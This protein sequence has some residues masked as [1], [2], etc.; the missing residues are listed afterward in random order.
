[1]QQFGWF[2]PAWPLWFGN[3]AVFGALLLAGLLGGELVHRLAALPRI[4]GYVLVGVLCGPQALGWVLE[5]LS[6][7]ARSVV[8]LALGLIVFELGHRLDLNWL[9]RNR[10]LALAAIGEMHRRLLRDLRRPALFRHR[11]PARRLRRGGRRGDLARGRDGGERRT[12]RLG[13]DHRAH[14]A[15]HRDQLRVRLRRADAVPAPGA[16]AARGQLALGDPAPAVP[17]GRRRHCSG[18]PAPRCCWDW[19]AG[20]ASAR[21]ASSSCW[22]RSWCWWSAAPAR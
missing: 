9:A 11:A 17:A 6:A 5:P 3:L 1:M 22:S 7:G 18:S 20:S 8:D 13:P 4:T 12:A 15:V 21:I 14:A 16:P 10:W 2:L 19:P